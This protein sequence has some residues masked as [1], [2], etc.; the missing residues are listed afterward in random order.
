MAKKRHIENS[1]LLSGQSRRKVAENLD[2][3][4]DAYAR[5]Y[6]NTPLEVLKKVEE[7]SAKEIIAK[8]LEAETQLIKSVTLGEDE[9]LIIRLNDKDKKK[10]QLEGLIKV[11]VLSTQDLQQFFIEV[12]TNQEN[13]VADTAATIQTYLR[14]QKLII[15]TQDETEIVRT[16]RRQLALLQHPDARLDQKLSSFLPD[17]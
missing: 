10:L 17:F 5:M 6:G 13:G 3:A 16:F 8:T 7:S 2:K 14:Y 4:K 12:I 11:L 15:I 9:F 1:S